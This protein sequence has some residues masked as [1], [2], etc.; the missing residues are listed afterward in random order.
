MQCHGVLSQIAGILVSA[1]VA[2]RWPS[3]LRV[4]YRLGKGDGL[5]ISYKGLK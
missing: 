1:T 3:R 4:P 2:N 5:I